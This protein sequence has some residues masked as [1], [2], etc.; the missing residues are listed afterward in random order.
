M[1]LEKT[2]NEQQ[3]KLEVLKRDLLTAGDPF[4]Q[5]W[6][7]LLQLGSWSTNQTKKTTRP[8]SELPKF[9]Q[10]AQTP[11]HPIT[12]SPNS[13]QLAQVPN[14]SPNFLPTLTY[15]FLRFE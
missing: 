5:K 7:F 2:N 3:I 11:T 13:G 4:R 10:L 14:N 8:I 1:K 15:F 12:E 9:C 6:D